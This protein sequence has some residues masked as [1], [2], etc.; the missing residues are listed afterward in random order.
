MNENQSLS[1]EGG[2]L[3]MDAPYRADS[4]D[5][6]QYSLQGMR[7]YRISLR[8]N[9]T[10]GE[11]FPQFEGKFLHIE[12][13]D[14]PCTIQLGNTS[15]NELFCADGYTYIGDFKGL[16][17]THAD[18]SA[19]TAVSPISIVVYIG[20][21]SSIVAPAVQLALRAPMPILNNHTTGLNGFTSLRFLCPDNA[22]EVT[23]ASIYSAITL[24]AL[25]QGGMAGEITF[26]S[27]P[28]GSACVVPATIYNGVNYNSTLSVTYR[29]ECRVILQ[30][31]ATFAYMVG[32]DFPS[33]PIPTWCREIEVRQ[34]V[35]AMNNLSAVQPHAGGST[36]GSAAL[37]VR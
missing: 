1:P 2:A 28:G 12:S 33:M 8:A 7:K 9:R 24:T 27:A 30:N 31:S 29:Q 32:V 4:Q 25:V 3:M 20:D 17:I 35:N 13:V 19:I 6:A 23:R 5:F 26:R 16:T 37:L 36:G 10:M 15:A 22:R 34:Y 14:V 18:Y 11:Y 21:G